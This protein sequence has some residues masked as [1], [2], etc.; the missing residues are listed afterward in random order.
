MRQPF[1]TQCASILPLPNLSSIQHDSF[2]Y[3]LEYGLKEILEEVNPIRDTT[4]RNWELSFES[5]RM[6]KPSTTVEGALRYGI[7]YDAAWYLTAKLTDAK[8]KKSKKQEIYMGDLP[9]MTNQGTFVINGIE[10]AV[11]NQLTRSEGVLFSEDFDKATGKRLAGA[12]ILPKNGAWLELETSKTGVISVK[13]DR[14]RKIV[15]TTLLRVFGLDTNDKIRTAFKSIDSNSELSYI[16]KTLERDV[17]TS[18]NEALLEIYRKMRPGEPLILENAKSLIDAMFF[19]TR[20]YSLG[21]VGRF[22]MNKKLGLE[23]KNEG[24][25]RLIQLEDLIRI[26]GRII[27]MNNGSSYSDDTDCLSNRRVR[28]VGEL[29]QLQ[30]RVGFLQMERNIKERMALQSRDALCDP[31]VLIS[32]RPVAARL[33]AFFASGQLS[34][35]Q[36]QTNPL[37]GLDHLRRLS[38]LG[39]GGLTRERA[40][41]SVRDAHYSHYGRICPT[42]TPEGSSI[43]LITYLALYAKVNEYGFIETPYRKLIHEKDGRVRV[44]EETVYLAAYDEQDVY[45]TDTSIKID[46]R[47][48]ILDSRVPLRRK[49][50]YTLGAVAQASYVDVVAEQTVGLTTSLIPFLAN[51]YIARA[52]VG[53]QQASQAVP[54]VKPS[55]PIV[56]TGMEGVT[57]R[58]S[59]ILLTAVEP[60]EVLEVNGAAVVIK[61]RATGKKQVYPL[62]KFVQ[63][64][65]K[66]CYNQ[67]PVVNVGQKVKKGDI[68]AEGPASQ[69]GELALGANLRIAYMYWE[70]YG[71]EDA[72]IISNRLVEEDVL[73]SIHITDHTTQVLETKLGNEEITADIPNVSDDALRN[74]DE[75]GLVTIGAKVKAGDILVGKIAPKGEQDLSAEER[76]LRAIFGEKAQEVKDNSLRMPNGEQ[77]TVIDVKVLTKA[78]ND[79]LAS[80][81]IKEIKVYVAQERKISVGDKLA[82]RHGNKGVIAKIVRKEDMPQDENGNP[83][84]IILSPA[85]MFSRMNLG[86]LFEAHLGAVGEKLGRTYTVP[87]FQRVSKD[88]LAHKLKEA[89]LPVSG[90]IRLTD[91]RTGEVFDQEV[92]VGNA[93]IFKLI[94]IAE[95]KLHA[96]STGPYSLITQQPLGGKSQFGGQRFGEMEVWALEAYGASHLLQEMLTIKSDD[97]VGRTKAYRAILQNQPLPESAVPESFKLLVRELNGLALK[98]EPLALNK[99]VSLAGLETMSTGK[100]ETTI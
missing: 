27:E 88:E 60:G 97:L 33:H 75:G 35:F 25:G 68:L 36:E 14:R 21:R 42:R 9:L 38:V 13:I 65:M 74:L 61:S 70:G 71:Y 11:I 73:T 58:N 54:L 62:K 4:G 81:V 1:G 22:R 18:Y 16:E 43:G 49:G 7:T 83:I 34:Q 52:L 98:I 84:D 77:G 30:A 28:S 5:P 37:A 91:G 10:R 80:G 69:G 15:I 79:E 32:P 26:I 48:Y 39:P 82:G 45:I 20:R 95:D 64:N 24:N 19:N 72:V 46:G 90:K 56:G 29:L 89:G 99:E 50:E 53:T 17:S 96:R 51:D 66:T 47:G 92:V 85:A 57:A 6:D 41:F 67:R 78:E 2:N 3:F 55:P 23:T 63:S 94:H 59:G 93:N 8:S 40:S 87:S 76:L 31:G 12:K 44:S 86:Q 100:E